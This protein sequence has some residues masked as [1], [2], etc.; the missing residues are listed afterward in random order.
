M[1]QWAQIFGSQDQ[2]HPETILFLGKQI[3]SRELESLEED[4]GDGK[5]V[6][7]TFSPL[8]SVGWSFRCLESFRGSTGPGVL[9]GRMWNHL[10]SFL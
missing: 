3:G 5:T 10:R 8:E 6:L 2:K 9:A 4:H 7:L 1:K